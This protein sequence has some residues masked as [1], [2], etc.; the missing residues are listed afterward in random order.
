[1]TE[2]A[3]KAKDITTKL[4][5]LLGYKVS[6]DNE[7]IKLFDLANRNN[8]LI[9]QSKKDSLSLHETEYVKSY[10]NF[11]ETYL[12]RYNSYLVFLTAIYFDKMGLKMDVSQKS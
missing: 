7:E 9:F 12:K 8:V 3:R 2:F 6:F 10:S 4:K 11:V 5:V 1:M